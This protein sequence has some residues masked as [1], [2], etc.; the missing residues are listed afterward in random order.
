[1]DDKMQDWERT[2]RQLGNTW[3]GSPSDRMQARIAVC[4]MCMAYPVRGD[5]LYKS[6]LQ[7]DVRQEMAILMLARLEKFEPSR[8]SLQDR[9]G[10]RIENELVKYVV[11]NASQCCSTAIK[12]VWRK[13]N[14]DGGEGIRHL[15]Q[16]QRNLHAIRLDQLIQNE[17]SKKPTDPSSRIASPRDDVERIN[18]SSLATSTLG[19]VAG[20]ILNFRKSLGKGRNKT[21][22]GRFYPLCF[23]EHMTFIT[24]NDRVNMLRDILADYHKDVLNALDWEYLRFFANGLPEQPDSLEDLY[25]AAPKLERDVFPGGEDKPLQFQGNSFFLKAK[26]PLAYY[27]VA[28]GQQRDDSFVTKNRKKYTDLLLRLR[29]R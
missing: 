11:V 17:I 23:S 2:L 1:M 22:D 27:D 29:D 20:V 18:S 26:V 25:H 7:D 8:V 28:Y 24:Q 21:I 13:N 3:T 12:I 14:M 9:K 16:K 6:T 10:N 5:G 19:A 15:P 4:E